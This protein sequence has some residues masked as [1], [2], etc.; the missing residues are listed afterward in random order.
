[1][2]WDCDQELEHARNAARSGMLSTATS[3][4]QSVYCRTDRACSDATPTALTN[5]PGSVMN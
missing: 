4:D 3:A 5:S 1:M 2:T